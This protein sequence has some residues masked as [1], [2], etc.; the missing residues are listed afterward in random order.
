MIRAS[1]LALL[2]GGAANAAFAQADPHAGH[3]MSTMPARD[4]PHAGHQPAPADPHAGHQT[5][6]ASPDPHA[7]HQAPSAPADPH[8]GHQMSG[9]AAPADPHAGYAMPAETPP[10]A[11]EHAGHVMGP[12]AGGQ[13]GADLPVGDAPPP[14]VIRDDM[15]DQVFDVGAMARARSILEA[16]HGG[17]RVS[18]LQADLLEW[19]PDG[20]RYSWQVEGWYGG[21]IN[22]FAFKTEGEGASGEGLEAAE[23]QLLYSRAVARYTDVQAG[24]RYDLEPRGR[25]YAT[26]GVDAL[27]PYWFEAEGALFLSDKGDLLARVEGSYDFRLTQRLILQPRTELE[28]AAQDIPESRIGSGL[29]RGEFGLRLRYEIRREFAPYIG[30]SYERSFGDTAD[31]V[32][33]DGEEPSSTRFVV[34]LRAW[35]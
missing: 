31:F 2:F 29:S 33:A 30:V 12:T 26:V 35:F 24:L 1:L 16:E 32:R 4:D 20:D 10:G 28:F 7:G 25:A 22:R 15:A 34:G 21:D 14:P 13:T 8:A 23:V 18:K 27:F 6:A 17:A 3:N 9:S 5:P 19:A 11:D